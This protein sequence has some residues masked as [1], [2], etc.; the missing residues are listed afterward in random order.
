MAS[1]GH[2]ELRW[3]LLDE[4]IS[5]L[6]LMGFLTNN[7][8]RPQY[9]RS[10]SRT[11]HELELIH[12][13]CESYLNVFMSDYELS[14][15]FKSHSNWEEIDF[16]NSSSASMMKLNASQ[17]RAR[18]WTRSECIASYGWLWM[19]SLHS[20]LVA[21]WWICLYVWVEVEINILYDLNWGKRCFHCIF[22]VNN[23][24]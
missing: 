2:N 1:L 19:Y 22:P 6:I 5:I 11:G 24:I 16:E 23:S 7:R 20:K 3:P 10:L 4:I 17:N 12:I 14:C 21:A 13:Y 8:S 15:D 18:V 9:H